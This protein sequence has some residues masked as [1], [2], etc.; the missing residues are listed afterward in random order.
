MP[1]TLGTTH[2]QIQR[3]WRVLKSS[4]FTAQQGD[5]IVLASDTLAHWLLTQLMKKSKHWYAL[6]SMT[7]LDEFQQFIAQERAELR[8][9]EDDIA[10]QIICL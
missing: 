1:D 3:S 4:W 2:E 5:Y 10:F 7:S 9:E 8:M 6:L